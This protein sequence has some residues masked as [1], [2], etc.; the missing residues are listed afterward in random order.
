[1]ARQRTKPRGLAAVVK[2]QGR[3]FVWLSRKTGYSVTQISRVARREHPGSERFHIA[4][5][6]ALGEDYAA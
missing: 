6:T 1:M 2:E 4:M 5:R 3:T